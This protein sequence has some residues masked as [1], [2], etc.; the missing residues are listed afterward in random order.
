MSGLTPKEAKTFKQICKL[1]RD[2]ISYGDYWTI[3]DEK[4]ITIVKQTVGEEPKEKICIPRF[5]FERFAN[6]Y[7]TGKQK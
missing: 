3:I 7:N 2:N 6:W 4:E 1:P 5:I